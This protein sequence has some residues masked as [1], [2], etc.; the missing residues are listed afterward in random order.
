M[1]TDDVPTM[2]TPPPSGERSVNASRPTSPGSN[3]AAATPPA[4][5][6]THASATAVAEDHDTPTPRPSPPE[7]PKDRSLAHDRSLGKNALRRLRPETIIRRT[8]RAFL[9]AFGVKSGIALLLKLFA[10]ARGKGKKSFFRSI[11]EV[12]VLNR[13]AGRFG[14]LFGL[15]TF[16][17]HT[18]VRGI[19]AIPELSKQPRRVQGMIAGAVAGLA[20]LVETKG[21]RLM[22]AQ[23]LSMRAL[24]AGYNSLKY[25]NL[26]HFPFGDSLLFIASCAQILFSYIFYPDTLPKEFYAFMI[27]MAQIPP[28][29]LG[30]NRIVCRAEETGGIDLPGLLAWAAKRKSTTPE[31]LAA[32]AASPAH[33]DMLPC[34]FLHPH[35]N[36]CS[37]YCGSLAKNVFTS[38]FPVYLTLHVMPTL[39][40][41]GRSV[42]SNPTSFASRAMFNTVRSSVFLAV[43]ISGYQIQTCF[44]RLLFK[45]GAIKQDHRLWYGWFGLVTAFSILIEDKKRRSELG[46]YVAP[47]AI[48]SLY[49]IMTRHKRWF[50]AVPFVDVALVCAATGCLSSFYVTGQAEHLSPLV[51]RILPRFVH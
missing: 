5:V 17:F 1:S 18:T 44:H 25:H 31:N 15:F 20:V 49:Q 30:A 3:A 48:H 50:P 34:C 32:I 29:V 26:F 37:W 8:L 11:L 16:L 6:D 45:L 47:K 13:D 9:L 33:L 36:S 12:T 28:N 27:K 43:F 42:L 24:Q 22:F 46:M 23:Q 38:I 19:H 2:V 14:L 35:S 10:L 7:S 40:F 4:R 51:K 39:I 41:R 21:N